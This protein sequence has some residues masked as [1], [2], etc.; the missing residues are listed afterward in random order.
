VPRLRCSTHT[1]LAWW[2]CLALCRSL[3][4]YPS[5]RHDK[6]CVLAPAPRPASKPRAETGR[7]FAE[8]TQPT[9]Q[10]MPPPV[11]APVTF[12]ARA[13]LCRAVA[14]IY[15]FRT[16]AKPL[17]A[18]SFGT[19]S[20]PCNGNYIMRTRM[21]PRNAHAP[22]SS[23]QEAAAPSMPRQVH[24]GSEADRADGYRLSASAQVHMQRRVP[25]RRALLAL[26]QSGAASTDYTAPCARHI[27]CSAKRP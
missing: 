16:L 3:S 7:K 11:L 14:C 13:C 20:T 6:V 2:A 18:T 17:L 10:L 25:G 1:T 4:S 22:F 21:G 12:P 5:L 24:R 8:C 27:R 23:V 26:A 19:R 9:V 15:L